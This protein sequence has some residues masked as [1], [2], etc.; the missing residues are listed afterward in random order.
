M[1]RNWVPALTRL[2]KFPMPWLTLAV[3]FTLLYHALLIDKDLC[4]AEIVIFLY[5]N[6]SAPEFVLPRLNT[7]TLS[8]RDLFHSAPVCNLPPST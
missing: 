3:D 8:K 4:Q 7:T 6:T 1:K 2:H 5:P